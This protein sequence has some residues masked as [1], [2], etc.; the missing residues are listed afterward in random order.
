[1]LVDEE[2]VMLEARVE[3]R[4]EA[5]LNDDRIVVTVDMRI[6]AV[7]PLEQLLDQRRESLGKGDTYK[8][9]RVFSFL[10]SSITDLSC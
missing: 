7:E 4:L 8:A 1:M 9:V 5:Q 6:D 2:H 3:V 10:S